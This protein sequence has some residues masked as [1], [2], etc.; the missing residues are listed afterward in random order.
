MTPLKIKTSVRVQRLVD[1]TTIS[2]LNEICAGQ[3]RADATVEDGINLGLKL[4]AEYYTRLR[5]RSLALPDPA[6]YSAT[7]NEHDG[8]TTFYFIG[9]LIE[10]LH[11][12][13]VDG[14]RN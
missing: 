1:N 5:R 4:A 7:A 2:S 13:K 6:I 11:D 12:L 10:V 3:L 14:E 8:T 9:H